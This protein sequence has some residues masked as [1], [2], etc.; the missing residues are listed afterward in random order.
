LHV[1]SI[2]IDLLNQAQV[3]ERLAANRDSA[4]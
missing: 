3:D 4:N 2:W 1:A